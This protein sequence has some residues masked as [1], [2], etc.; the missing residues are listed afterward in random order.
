MILTVC[1]V[2]NQD[3]TPD[4]W[5]ITGIGMVS[6]TGYCWRLKQYFFMEDISTK[7]SV[8]AGSEF[9]SDILVIH[10][11]ADSDVYS[12]LITTVILT[13]SLDRNLGCL[14]I[15]DILDDN[16]DKNCP[17]PSFIDEISV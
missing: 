4:Q 6:S 9:C 8:I 15:Y 16:L 14:T 11:T 17:A 5:N 3:F 1:G 12:N 10:A 13:D 2:A 7:Q